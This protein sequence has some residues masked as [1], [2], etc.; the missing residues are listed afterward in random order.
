MI[1]LIWTEAMPAGAV[2]TGPV[3]RKWGLGW[4]NGLTARLWL[5][6]VWELALSGGPNDYL[7]QGEVHF[8]DT[9]YPP[10]WESGEIHAYDDDKRES[11][12]VEFQAG[13]LLARRG[14]LAAVGF[15]GLNYS[16]SDSRDTD[17]EID[18]IHPDYSYVRGVAYD[19]SNFTLTLGFRPSVVVL[20]HLTLEAA[21]WLAYRWFEEDATEWREYPDSGRYLG[22][23]SSREGERFYFGGWS[24]MSSLQ[25]IFWF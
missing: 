23:V 9:G 6:G 16:W 25:I 5:G 19:E 7:A 24:G 10:N 17:Q 13:R 12:F 18:V 11:G 4:A 21:F 14:P 22:E 3:E 15:L 2:E 1:L 8:Q 20:D